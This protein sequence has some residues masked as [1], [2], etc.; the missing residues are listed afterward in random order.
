VNKQD[1]DFDTEKFQKALVR[2]NRL[3]AATRT[4]LHN[5]ISHWAGF[6]KSMFGG[7]ANIVIDEQ[8][9]N[10]TGDVLGKS[11]AITFGVLATDDFCRVEAIIFSPSTQANR[12]I[13]VGRFYFGSDGRIFSAN[14]EVLVHEHEE[15]QSYSLL[16][17]VLRK[18]LSTPQ[19]V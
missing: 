9:K 15:F 14:N 19:S 10:I 3:L 13:E 17:A 16:V 1:F 6:T 18:V 5:A 2:N 7:S 4:H 8:S 11:F 12:E